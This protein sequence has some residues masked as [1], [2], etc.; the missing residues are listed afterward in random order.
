MNLQLTSKT[1]FVSGSTQGIGFAIAKQLLQEGAHVII[2]GRNNE[3]VA[4]A[5]EKLRLAIPEAVVSGIT[6]NFADVDEVT[7]LLTQLPEIDILVNNVGI[8][9]LKQFADITDQDWLRFFEVNV[10]SGVRLS[11]AL[12]PKMIEKT[13]G[14]V[15]FISSESAVKIPG[16]MIHYAMTK[17]AMISIARGLA[18]LTKGTSVTV[19]TILGGPTYS[20]GVSGVVE[21]IAATA[22][23]EVEQVKDNLSKTMNPTSLLQRFITPSEL[24]NLVVYLSS[25]LSAATNGSALRADGGLLQTIL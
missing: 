14:R 15:I 1:A 16:N 17:T 24:A 9:E 21:Q 6:A 4:A 8:F 2:N 10:M 25:P 18:E 22:N 11:R 19:N 13:Q 20:E 12:L 7:K 23:I 3:K 5:V